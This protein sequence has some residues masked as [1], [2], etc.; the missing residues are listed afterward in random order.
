MAKKALLAGLCLG[1]LEFMPHDPA[2]GQPGLPGRFLQ[3]FG[4]LG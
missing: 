1:A 2:S 3:P 4:K